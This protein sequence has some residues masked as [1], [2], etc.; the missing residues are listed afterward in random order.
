MRRF[1]QQTLVR[2]CSAVEVVG[3]ATLRIEDYRVYVDR[4]VRS[5]GGIDSDFAVHNSVF[6]RVEPGIH[7]IIF[8]DKDFRDPN[9][10]ESNLV[11]SDIPAHQRIV[12]RAGLTEQGLALTVVGLQPMPPPP[13]I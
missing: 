10:R 2:E 12:L 5:A 9:R 8:R 13:V 1:F 4:Y 6:A 7:T 11:T 3:D